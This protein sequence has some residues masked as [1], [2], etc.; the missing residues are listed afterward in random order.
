MTI[1]LGGRPIEVLLV[2][3]DP[4]DARLTQETLKGSTYRLNVNL[5]EDGEVAMARL[6]KE[7][8]HADA[9]RPDLILLD[10]KMPKK[11]G[12]EVL[13]EM[14]QDAHLVQ[15]P[16]MILTGNL[17]ERSR[18]VSYNIPPSRW[19]AKPLDLARFDQAVSQL[20][21]DG[22]QSRKLHTGSRS[23]QESTRSRKWWWPYGPR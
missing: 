15:I 18:L 6:R 22:D 16:V 20:I 5:A 13:G 10:L 1:S 21:L 8:Q 7:G 11:S 9:P 14:N 19:C 3:D 17:A 23:A 2:E 4:A 12:E